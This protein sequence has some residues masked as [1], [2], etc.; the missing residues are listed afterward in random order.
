[1]GRGKLRGV[2]SW[3]MEEKE[4]TEEEKKGRKGE[5]EKSGDEGTVFD[6]QAR[7]ERRTCIVVKIV[8]IYA[9]RTYVTLIKTNEKYFSFLKLLGSGGIISAEY[10]HRQNDPVLKPS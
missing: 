5:E 3:W 1:M 10:F 2:G 4:R 9:Y 7:R 8:L 6:W